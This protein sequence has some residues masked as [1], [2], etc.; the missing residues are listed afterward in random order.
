MKT[1]DLV[2]HI[3]GAPW[4][5]RT[6]IGIV[7]AVGDTPLARPWVQVHWPDGEEP[8]THTADELELIQEKKNA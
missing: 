5:P 8:E 3:S 6:F 4:W 7:L 1:G 2:K